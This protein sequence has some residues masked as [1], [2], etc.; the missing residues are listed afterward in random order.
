M[1]LSL[2]FTGGIFDNVASWVSPDASHF[3]AMQARFLVWSAGQRQ[4]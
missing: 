3:D 1:V 4:P 2:D